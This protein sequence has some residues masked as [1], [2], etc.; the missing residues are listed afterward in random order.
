M[1]AAAQ[2]LLVSNTGTRRVILGAPPKSKGG[3]KILKFDTPADSG[4]PADKRI[5]NV[6]TL[7]GADAE[8]VR[9]SKVFEAVKDRLSLRVG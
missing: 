5:G 9:S 3:G 7:T 2:S 4:V 6:H 1:S 8:R